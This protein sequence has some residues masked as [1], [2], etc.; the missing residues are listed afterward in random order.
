VEEDGSLRRDAVPWDEELRA[1]ALEAA[2]AG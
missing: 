2:A 1:E